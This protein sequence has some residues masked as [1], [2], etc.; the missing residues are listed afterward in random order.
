MNKAFRVFKGYRERPYDQAMLK[1]FDWYKPEITIPCIMYGDLWLTQTKVTIPGMLGIERYSLDHYPRVVEWEDNY[2]LE[3]GHHRVL[4][5]F[6][7]A[8][9]DRGLFK[10][11]TKVVSDV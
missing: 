3:D 1:D 11:W 4:R 9:Q 6:L 7:M 5:D 10:L 2:Y 8:N